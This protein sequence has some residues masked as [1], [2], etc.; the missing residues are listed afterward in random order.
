VSYVTSARL[1][2][3]RRL[4]YH[5]VMEALI[6]TN[7]R[8]AERL[9]HAEA[10]RW[11]VPE[12]A[13]EDILQETLARTVRYWKLADAKDPTAYFLG[14]VYLNA[15]TVVMRLRGFHNGNKRPQAPKAVGEQATDAVG[16]YQEPAR[17]RTTLFDERDSMLLDERIL[18]TM[19]SAEDVYL[20]TVPSK[21]QTALREAVDSLPERQRVVLT[22][23][24]Y[25]ELS[26]A[27]S[28]SALGLTISE[29]SSLRSNAVRTLKRKLN[30]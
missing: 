22:H 8:A 23:Q 28:A 10:Y 24:F 21:R 3:D 18:P 7:W 30:A 14:A 25:E 11:Y 26:V 2:S 1:D 12:H 13:H 27:E 16:L 19:P 9:V 17:S 15:K 6:K 5:E 4:L 29:V 20:A